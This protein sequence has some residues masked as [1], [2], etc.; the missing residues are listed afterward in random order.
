MTMI[1]KSGHLNFQSGFLSRTFP[2]LTEPV[3]IRLDVDSKLSDQIKVKRQEAVWYEYINT[4]QDRLHSF[5]L[6]ICLHCLVIMSE[7]SFAPP[8]L[9][10]FLSRVDDK[11][12]LLLHLLRNVVKPQEQTVVFVATKHHVEYIKEV[13]IR[14]LLLPLRHCYHCNH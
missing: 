2:G 13:R 12:A 1:V 10:F 8:Q 3:L 6:C 5:Y 9:S 4:V 7:N 14:Q 11:S